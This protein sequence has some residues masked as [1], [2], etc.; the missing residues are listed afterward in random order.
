MYDSD[1]KGISYT[2]GFFILIGF[3][4]A[5]IFVAALISIPVW[6]GMTGQSVFNME[7]DMTIPEYSNAFKVISLITAVVGFFLPAFFTALML[8]RKPMKLL[9]FKGR[10]STG[11]ASLIV[12]IVIFS[13][14]VSGAMAYFNEL[15][16]LTDKLKTIF[17]RWEKNYN[18]QVEVIISLSN[19]PEYLLA[20]FLLAVIPAVTEETLFRGGFQ[21]FLTRSTRVPWFSIIFVSLIFS[22]VHGSFYGYLSRFFLG[23]MLGLI[24]HLSGR[25]W[26]SILAHFI[27]NFAAVTFIYIYKLQG[28]SIKE[29]IAETDSTW[30]GILALPAVI[31]LF[32]WFQRISQKN[33]EK[34]EVPVSIQ[35]NPGDLFPGHS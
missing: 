6:T 7:K 24:F 29:A 2:A 25:L 21:N 32:V 9:G 10:I 15:I 35:D 31:V 8:N 4:F 34:E 20:V 27:N 16:P 17:D 18:E 33:K 30:W 5:F 1:S 19:F 11:Q 14:F 13:L 28:K 26:L 23:I 12:P 22:A 3:T